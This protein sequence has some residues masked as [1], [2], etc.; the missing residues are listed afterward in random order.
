MNF[1]TI[2]SYVQIIIRSRLDQSVEENQDLKVGEDLHIF[3][4]ESNRGDVTCQLWGIL[5]RARDAVPGRAE[6]YLCCLSLEERDTSDLLLTVT[7][8]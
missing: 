5:E 1:M 8:F 3:P 6:P 2:L 4:F 7:T